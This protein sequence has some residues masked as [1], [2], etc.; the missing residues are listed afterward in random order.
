MHIRDPELDEVAKEWI[1]DVII[2]PNAAPIGCWIL[3]LVLGMTGR[4][5]PR[6]EDMRMLESIIVRVEWKGGM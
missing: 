3:L 6:K 2:P 1:I 5:G 4:N